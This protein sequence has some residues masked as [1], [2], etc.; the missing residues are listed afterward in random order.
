MTKLYLQFNFS[1]TSSRHGLENIES[2]LD[3]YSQKRMSPRGETFFE[4]HRQHYLLLQHYLLFVNKFSLADERSVNSVLSQA[5]RP[6]VHSLIN[7]LEHDSRY[8]RNSK[9]EGFI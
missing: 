3:D 2:M 7:E 5:E 8:E 1:Y 6:T 9:N 4:L